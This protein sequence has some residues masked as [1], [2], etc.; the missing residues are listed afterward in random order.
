MD[1]QQRVE[2]FIMNKLLGYEYIGGRHTA[3]DNLPKG[4]PPSGRGTFKA[5][6]RSLRKKGLIS[7]KPTGYGDQVSATPS[8]RVQALELA[9]A[10]RVSAG[11]PPLGLDLKEQKPQSATR[12]SS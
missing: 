5:A 12:K 3:V 7:I 9:N 6:V 4:Y 10:F 1:D 11:M 8:M 2:G